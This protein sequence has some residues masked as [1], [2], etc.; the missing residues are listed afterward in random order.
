MEIRVTAKSKQDVEVEIE[1]ADYSIADIIRYELL[2][3]KNVSFA[4]IITPHPLL[5]RIKLTVIAK[6]DALKRIKMSADKA[7]KFADE[8]LETSKKALKV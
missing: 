3:D 8:L 2:E 7:V 4:G 5:K 1:D 6:D